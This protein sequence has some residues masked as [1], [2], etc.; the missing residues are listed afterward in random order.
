MMK[1]LLTICLLSATIKP[2]AP[3]QKSTKE[4]TISFM[5]RTLK[6]TTG[7]EGKDGKIVEI[8]LNQ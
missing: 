8:V 7:F 4:G 6:F 3:Q 2:A 1:K 5:N